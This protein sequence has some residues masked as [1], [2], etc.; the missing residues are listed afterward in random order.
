M[1]I[2]KGKQVAGRG[3]YWDTSSWRRIDVTSQQTLPGDDTVT[4]LKLP[5]IIV[6]FLGP[7]VGLIYVV[8]L[9][10][11]AIGAVL[12]PLMSKLAEGLFNLLVR[13][14]SFGWRPT[15]SYLAGRKKC[16]KKEE[17]A[18]RDGHTLSEKEPLEGKGS[19]SELNGKSDCK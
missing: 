17:D 12:V 8:F 18:T 10:F 4:Y 11:L 6:L 2:F 7:I 16:E 13:S 15:A 3:T 19:R 5:S 1:L 14:V 9:P